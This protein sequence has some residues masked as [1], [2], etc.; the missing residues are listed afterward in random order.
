M[1]S[2]VYNIRKDALNLQPLLE[3]AEKVAVYNTLSGKDAL[4]LRLLAEELVSM[5]PSI[6]SGFD[7]E[8]WIANE[9]NCYEICVR[10]FVEDMDVSTRERLI[11]VSTDNKNSSVVG[12]SGRIRAVFDHMAM[13][14]DKRITSPAGKY[15]M[16]TDIDFSQIWSMKEYRENVKGESE[17]KWDEFEKSILVK[18]ADDVIVGVSGK[19][20]EII[21][22]KTV[23]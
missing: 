6:V 9:G 11:K 5:L 8:F 3:E 12:L 1:Q 10:V 21:I 15:G 14:G 19:K 4:S 2:N 22:K 20:V 17:E 16:A 13:V 18:I 23:N 7:G